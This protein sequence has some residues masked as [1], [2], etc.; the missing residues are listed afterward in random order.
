MTTMEGT[1]A[2]SAEAMVIGRVAAGRIEVIG[3]IGVIGDTI[4]IIG[5][6]PLNKMLHHI[7]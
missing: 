2:T 6:H 4:T 5:D 3:A 1:S 7:K